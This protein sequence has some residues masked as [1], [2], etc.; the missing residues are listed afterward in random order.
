MDNSS[1][2]EINV[3]GILAILFGLFALYGSFL[4]IKNYDEYINIEPK[5]LTLWGII[6]A[7]ISG[8]I[9]IASGIGLLRF[10]HWGRFLL[11]GIS[12]Y[13]LI[14]RIIAQIVGLELNIIRSV[15]QPLLYAF[16][17]YYL[18]RPKVKEMFK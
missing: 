11:I 18:T 7:P 15:F 4:L 13:A 10:R 16:I 12:I 3:V 8:I 9:F 1:R 17:I 2:T 5:A 6:F 14:M